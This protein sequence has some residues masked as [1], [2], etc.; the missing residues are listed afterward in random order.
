MK[1]AL[2]IFAIALLALLLLTPAS[3]HAADV[4][5][6]VGDTLTLKWEANPP[7]DGV[8]HYDVYFCE[9]ADGPFTKLTSVIGNQ[10]TPVEMREGPTY[11]KIIAEDEA[12]N[13]SDASAPSPDRFIFD[14]TAPG[15]PGVISFILIVAVE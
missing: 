5:I 11:F 6:G 7:E 4:Y 2:A 1:N 8:K 9:T 13:R 14:R 12:R 3:A 10:L 15:T